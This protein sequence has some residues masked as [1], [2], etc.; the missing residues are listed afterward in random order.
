MVS[1]HTTIFLI[2]Q[3]GIFASEGI[4]VVIESGEDQEVW[5]VR[6]LVNCLDTNSQLEA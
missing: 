3:N 6:E 5:T 4:R 2:P 1:F